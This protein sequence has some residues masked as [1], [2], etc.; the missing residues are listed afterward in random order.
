MYHGLVLEK[1]HEKIAKRC[2]SH[3]TEVI[4]KLEEIGSALFSRGINAH[5]LCNVDLID[6]KVFNHQQWSFVEKNFGKAGKFSGVNTRCT[7]EI[8]LSEI[9]LFD[10]PI[11]IS[12]S[13]GVKKGDIFSKLFSACLE[14]VIR[15]LNWKKV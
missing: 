3:P 14:I 4:A 9:T 2:D 12:V 5:F 6:D 11:S 10:T 1:F 8:T 7:T 15:T 13:K